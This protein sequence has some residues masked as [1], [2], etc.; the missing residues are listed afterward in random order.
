ML[1]TLRK[2]V[3]GDI[4]YKANYCQKYFVKFKKVTNIELIDFKFY[5]FLEF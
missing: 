2:S 3:N 4:H 5:L 1:V